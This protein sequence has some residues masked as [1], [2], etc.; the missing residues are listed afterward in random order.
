M[1]SGELEP[2]LDWVSGLAGRSWLIPERDWRGG[3]GLAGDSLGN[4]YRAA[5][6]TETNQGAIMADGVGINAD[7]WPRTKP[8]LLSINKLFPT[9][10]VRK[11][12]NSS[13]AAAPQTRQ[14][15]QKK[16]RKNGGYSHSR[17]LEI[18]QFLLSIPSP[19]LLSTRQYLPLPGHHHLTVHSSGRW[20]F[21]SAA[22]TDLMLDQWVL[23]NGYGSFQR[24]PLL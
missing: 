2:K 24:L 15:G 9:P 3:W 21:V 11:Q 8:L 23:W 1:V 22:Y 4:G 5:E 10:Y 19:N 13:T 20:A 12:M 14:N 16:D 6:Q 7:P 18:P 17:D